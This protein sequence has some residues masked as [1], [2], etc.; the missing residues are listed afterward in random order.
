MPLFQQSV[1]AK[2][3]GGAKRMDAVFWKREKKATALQHVIRQTDKD[4][5]AMVY[6]LYGLTEAEVAIVEGR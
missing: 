3:K 4:I 1:L 5:D 6:R 2:Y